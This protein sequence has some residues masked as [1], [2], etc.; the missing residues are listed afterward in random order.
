ME[1]GRVI[2]AAI[3]LFC[4]FFSLLGLLVVALAPALPKIKRLWFLSLV[5]VGLAFG[6]ISDRVGFQ[7]ITETGIYDAGSFFDYSSNTAHVRWGYQP[8]VKGSRFR[9]FYKYKY[10]DDEMGPY[11]LPSCPVEDC[12]ADYQLQIPDGQSWKSVIFVCYAEYVAPPVVT[13]NGV[14]HLSGV[15]RT[16]DDSQRY[17]TP[18]VTIEVDGEILTPTNS[19]GRPK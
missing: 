5:V 15:M 1:G 19:P 2:P 4:L 12:A 16:M 3:V 14:Y 18:L 10:G 13:T 8:Y 11:E 9:W 7:I 6:V 17:V